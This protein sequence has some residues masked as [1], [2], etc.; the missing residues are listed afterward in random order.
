MTFLFLGKNPLFLKDLNHIWIIM[1][2]K[3]IYLNLYFIV[4]LDESRKGDSFV[5]FVNNPNESSPLSENSPAFNRSPFR[6]FTWSG[7]SSFSSQTI[8]GTDGVNYS[9]L[10]YNLSYHGIQKIL[11]PDKIKLLISWLFY[12][13]KLI[14]FT[15]IFVTK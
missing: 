12:L 10:S 11:L 14:I 4:D 2:F 6:S 5:D 9:C 7:S 15:L 8:S 1:D 3:I 13:M